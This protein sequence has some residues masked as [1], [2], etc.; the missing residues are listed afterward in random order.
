MKKAIQFGAG[1]IGRGFIGAVLR[2]SSYDVL[3][4]DV[5]KE[6]IDKINKDKKY[7]VFIKDEKLEEEIIDKVSGIYA[8]DE[9]LLEKISESDVITTAVGVSILPK[10]SKNIADGIKRKI[11]KEN[12]N[13]LNIIACENA[14]GATEILKNEVFKFLNDEEKEF[15]EKFIGFVDCSVDRI[16]P[17]ND[18]DSIDVLA[19]K[20]YEWNLQKDQIVGELNIVDANIV[21][22]L[23]AYVERKL[24]TLNTGH[25][26]CAYLGFLKNYETIYDSINDEFIYE[27]VKE[28]MI[29]SG[30]GFIEKYNFNREN[31]LLY[32]DKI[33]K[34]F[35]NPHL[36][37][38][39][40]RVGREPMRK[41]SHNDRFVKPILTAYGYGKKI[42]K[43]CLGVASALKFNS[44]KDESSVKMQ[45]LINEKGVLT[46]LE[47]LSGIH[48]EEILSK[49]FEK[50]NE[51]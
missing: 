34:R 35:K 23:Q 40:L 1:N 27:N 24:F 22:N 46:A 3:F 21:E 14:V 5:N 25:T 7:K 36:V 26:M 32:I 29:E 42:D 48:Q 9:N 16:V 39:V 8:D 41:L 51:I 38:Y 2:K 37:D 19:E 45:E 6:I 30:E 20:F 10:I 50:F 33:I 43:L 49:I 4:C 17:T 31:H 15:C 28:A 47:E 12:R 18:L 11:S 44:P 13:Y